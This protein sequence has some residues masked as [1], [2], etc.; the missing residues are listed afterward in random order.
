MTQL[1]DVIREKYN[2]EWALFG[3]K[4]SDSMNR[5]LM[6]RTYKDEAIN[7]E[8]KKCYPLSPYKNKDILEYIEEKSLVRPEKYGNTQSAGTSV[9][10][11]NYL[12]FLR[13]EHPDDLERVLREYPLV[14]RKLFEYDY[15][16]SKTE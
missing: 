3:F 7:E 1:T 12:L 8:Q 4:Q 10:D 2:V 9:S 11:M 5:R 14:E 6:L 15:E 13:N 16:K